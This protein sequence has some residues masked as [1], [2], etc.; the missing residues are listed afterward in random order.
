[1]KSLTKSVTALALVAM[2]AV[3]FAV[4]MT[5]L[6]A[7]APG[8]EAKYAGLGTYGLWINTDEYQPPHENAWAGYLEIYNVDKD[9]T[10]MGYCLDYFKPLA[11]E[12]QMVIDD[13]LTDEEWCLVNWVLNNYLA[14]DA[15]DPNLEAAAIQAVI[16]MITSGLDDL[17]I[18]QTDVET[19]VAQIYGALPEAGECSFPVSIELSPECQTVGLGEC[20]V[21]TAT[22]LGSDGMPFQGAEV[23]FFVDACVDWSDVVMTD[24][25]GEAS[26]EVCCCC[27]GSLASVTA[28]VK[29]GYGRLVENILEDGQDVVLLPG[30]LSD[31]AC[32][33]CCYYPDGY[34]IG[35]WKTNIGKLWCFQM[36]KGT[37]VTKQQVLTALAWIDDLAENHVIPAFGASYNG[38]LDWLKDLTPQKAYQI[39]NFPKPVTPMNMAKAQMLATLLTAGLYEQTEGAGYYLNGCLDMPECMEDISIHEAM[40]I[41]VTWFHQG[42]YAKAAG[43]ADYINNQPEGGY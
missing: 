26:I 41:M 43:L 5:A 7:P 14:E 12:D 23:T 21:V 11:D 13:L 4:P 9:E 33:R 2:M 17:G 19:R 8:D 38:K 32:V 25:D 18:L 6:A 10:Y 27:E 20:G 24:C 34:T 31:G 3:A 15:S 16:W 30:L 1:M 28:E 35:F 36:G 37:Q 22:V 40:H 29:G 39:L 42:K